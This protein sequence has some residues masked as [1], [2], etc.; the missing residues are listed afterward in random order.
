MPWLA[1]PSTGPSCRGLC[2]CEWVRD[3]ARICFF[4]EFLS[5]CVSGQGAPRGQKRSSAARWKEKTGV[6]I[7][8][9]SLMKG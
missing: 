8:G 1:Q 6:G 5:S 9:R 4:E 3:Q 2:L 7:L